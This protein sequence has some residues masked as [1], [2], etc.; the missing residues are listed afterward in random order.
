MVREEIMSPIPEN[1][2][3]GGIDIRV[4][5]LPSSKESTYQNQ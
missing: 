5:S 3:G 2:L 1:R 4:T